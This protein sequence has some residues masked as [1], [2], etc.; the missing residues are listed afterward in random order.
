MVRICRFWWAAPSEIATTE[1]K[2]ET[3]V[4]DNE[5]FFNVR[6]CNCQQYQSQCS[7]ASKRMPCSIYPCVM[8]CHI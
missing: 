3:K 5:T 2:N 6:V 4:F 8:R 7:D 1:W